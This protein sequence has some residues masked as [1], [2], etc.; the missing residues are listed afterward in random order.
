MRHIGETR[1]GASHWGDEGRCVT[2]GAQVGRDLKSQGVHVR[3]S[4]FAYVCVDVDVNVDVCARVCV[5][6]GVRV[7][8]RF[9]YV[10]V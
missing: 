9:V 7:L 3:V 4:V 5:G 1:D 6:V 2:G 10:D 8:A